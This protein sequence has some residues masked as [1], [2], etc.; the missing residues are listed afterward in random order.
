MGKEEVQAKVDV[1]PA[2]ETNTLVNHIV[3][4]SSSGF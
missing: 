3:Y 4:L 1:T 2:K